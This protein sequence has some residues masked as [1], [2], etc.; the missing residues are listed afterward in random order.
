V[1]LSKTA[2]SGLLVQP[3]GVSGS[4]TNTAR[5]VSVARLDTQKEARYARAPRFA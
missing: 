1:G 3:V 5:C 2:W 4:V